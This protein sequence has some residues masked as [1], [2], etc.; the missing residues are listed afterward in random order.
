MPIDGVKITPLKI[1]ETKGGNVLHAM[2]NSDNGYMGFG[3][4]YFSVV[5]SKAI[6]GW[7]RHKNMVLNL[8]VP[9][10][11][12]RFVLLDDREYQD[13]TNYFYE[14]ILNNSNSYSRLTIPPMIWV[15]F[16]GISSQS[17]ILLNIANIEHS[18]DEVERKDLEELKFNWSK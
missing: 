6:K 17:S 9:V 15:G 13:N 1:I 5:E 14:V 18:P 4:A 12:V 7:K 3:E 8:V 10:G 16:Q 11:S 2:K